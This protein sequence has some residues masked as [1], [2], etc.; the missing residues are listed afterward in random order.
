MLGGR[1]DENLATVLII[2]DDMVS[3][4]VMATVLTMSGYLIHTAA[5]GEDAVALLDG[6]G[7]T[8]DVILMDTQM[9]GLQGRALVDALRHR[10]EASIYA[11]SGSEV[12]ADVRAAVDGYLSKPFGP[13]NLQQLIEQHHIPQPKEPEPEAPVMR[14]ETLAQLRS[15]MP[16]SG[17]REIFN[18]VVTDLGVRHVALKTAFSRGDMATIRKIG[19]AIKGGCGMA[20][21]MQAA[22]IGAQLEATGDHLDDGSTLLAELDTARGNLK[23]MLDAEFPLP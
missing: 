1:D 8:P 17:V 22:R 14:P 19:H 5:Q 7:C 23:R 6:G 11:M 21:A 12:P 9:P 3:R 4:E 18:A 10:S 13:Q 20:G 15:M 2:D 16:A